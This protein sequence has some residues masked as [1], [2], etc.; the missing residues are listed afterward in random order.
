MISQEQVRVARKLGERL[1]AGDETAIED[2]GEVLA[3]LIRAGDEKFGADL[4]MQLMFGMMPPVVFDAMWRRH[5]ARLKEG[6]DPKANLR[7]RTELAYIKKK[8]A[9]AKMQTLHR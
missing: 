9:A 7:D 2:I 5:T 8:L 3:S 6:R 4:I 1:A